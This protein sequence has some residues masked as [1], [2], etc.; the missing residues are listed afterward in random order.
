[1]FENTKKTL[2]ELE[3]AIHFL[4]KGIFDEEKEEVVAAFINAQDT[5]D[6]FELHLAESMMKDKYIDVNKL[7]KILLVIKGNFN[8]V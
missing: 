7:A 8:E 5:I 1:M 4:E 2:L 3:N 6:Y